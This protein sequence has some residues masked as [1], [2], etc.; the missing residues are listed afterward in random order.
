[1]HGGAQVQ[2]AEAQLVQSSFDEAGNEFTFKANG[3]D[4]TAVMAAYANLLISPPFFV[5]WGAAHTL[6]RVFGLG[7]CPT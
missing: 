1:M 6:V 4:V 3:K 7:S 2:N 5:R